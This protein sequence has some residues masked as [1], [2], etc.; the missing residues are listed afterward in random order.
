MKVREC[1]NEVEQEDDA[2][3][4]IAQQILQKSTDFLTRIIVPVERDATRRLNCK[5]EATLSIAQDI[6]RN[7]TDFLRRI[8]APIGGVERGRIVV[9]VPSLSVL[10][11]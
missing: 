8:F 2:R 6:L 11:A 10:P 3:Q 7:S 4:S 9:R 1:N 5:T